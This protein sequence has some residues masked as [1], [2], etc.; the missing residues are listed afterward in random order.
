MAQPRPHDRRRTRLLATINS[1]D[2]EIMLSKKNKKKLM[3]T[4]ISGA[5]GTVIAG[6][7]GLAFSLGG[8]GVPLALLGCIIG[9][10]LPAL[11]EALLTRT[12]KLSSITILILDDDPRDLEKHTEQLKA[13]GFNCYPTQDAKDAIKAATEN[14]SIQFGII[15]QILNIP[16]TQDR[17]DIQGRGVVKKIHHARPD[18]KFIFVT[19][20]PVQ[21]AKTDK[22]F[23]IYRQ[24][25][26]D[27]KIPGVVLEV[28]DK[29]EI[30]KDPD[31]HYDRI[32]TLIRETLNLN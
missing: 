8:L 23:E 24:K 11:A 5:I 26:N 32:L 10:I 7:G 21:A 25:I 22:N 2:R 4:A 16:G 30:E 29:D 12:P 19:N 18:L 15:D 20:Q 31:H 13:V 6:V 28:I 17:Q 9:G 3:T 1:S 27:L 14:P